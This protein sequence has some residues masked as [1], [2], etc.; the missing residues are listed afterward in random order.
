LADLSRGAYADVLEHSLAAAALATRPSE[1]LGIAALAAT[2]SDDLDQARELKNR[3]A[4]AAASPTLSAFGAYVN[5]EIDAA[6]GR[7][8]HAEEHYARAVDL[9]QTSGATFVV[10]I[11]SVGLLTVRASTGRMHDALRGYHD[12]IGY[13]DRAGNWTQQWATLRNLAH[14]LHRLGDHEPAA[15]LDMA[16]EHAPDSPAV[17]ISPGPTDAAARS[18]PSPAVTLRPPVPSRASTLEVARQAILRNL[19]GS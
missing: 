2:Y 3:M 9:A 15:L 8:D 17:G 12:V 6:S 13:W 5:G 10:G 11:A 7:P 4:A 16:A 18:T 14:L 19:A 1:D